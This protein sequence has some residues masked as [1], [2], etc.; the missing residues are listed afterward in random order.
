MRKPTPIAAAA[1]LATSAI[2][3]NRLVLSPST[4]ASMV[5]RIGVMS[6]ATI[7]APMTVAVESPP[8][9]ADAMIDSR[10]S[11]IHNRLSRR[12]RS[13][14]SKNTELRMWSRSLSAKFGIV[15]T[16]P[17]LVMGSLTIVIPR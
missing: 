15:V 12:P 7:M 1:P 10:V 14:P 3:R 2:E 6:G 5:P 16:V 17:V 9:P 11:R 13:G 4:T 8:T